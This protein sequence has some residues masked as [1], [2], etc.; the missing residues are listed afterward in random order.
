[1]LSAD[2]IVGLTDGE[3]CF[4]VNVRPPDKRWAHSK[5]G[6]ETHFY[7]KMKEDELGLLEKVKK[8]FGRGGIYHQKEKRPNHTPCYRYEINSQKDVHEVL[9]PFFDKHPLQSSKQKSYR[10]F[11]KIAIMIKN[12][13]YRKAEGI[14]KI[15]QLK[16]KMN[17]GARRVREIRLLGGNAK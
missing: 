2:Y 4:Y 5:P 11:R 8:F 15:I 16:S 10:I 6:V 3:G 7:L 12:R 14:E 13:E 1:M 9:I 17:F